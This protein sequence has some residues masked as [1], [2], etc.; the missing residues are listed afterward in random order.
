MLRRLRALLSARRLD[1]ELDAELRFH[2]EMEAEQ[3]V[4]QGLTPD[5]ARARAWRNFGPMVK[6]TEGARDQ[7]GVGAIE[8]FVQDLRYGVRIL[9]K[10]PGFAL[11]SILTLGL[12]IA[13]NT[14][15]FSVIDAAY[16]SRYPLHEPD[17]LI[18]LFNEDRERGA[19]QVITFS[20]PRYTFFRERQTSF[21]GLAAA[22]Y[23]GFTLEN[24]GDAEQIPGA[25]I[26]SDFLTTFGAS[27]LI[28]R[29]M[30]LDEEEG[31]RVVV[32]GEEMWR[33]RFG[34]SAAVLGQPLTLSGTVYTIVGVAPRLPAFW[35]ADVWLPDPFIVPGLTRELMQR[36]VTF[37]SL[38]GRLQP[39][40][41]QAEATRE[42][43]VLASR[44]GDAFP[45][46][47]DAHW[48]VTT[49]GLRDNIVGSSR[50]SL[51]TL[52]AAVGLLL[53]VAC[54]NV[55]NLLL[56]RFTGRRQEIGLRAALGASRAR[57]V[58]Q[59]L[60][61]STV[62]ATLAAA[63]GAALAYVATPALLALAQNNLAFSEDIHISLPVLGATVA[64]AL[65][66]GLVMGAYPSVQGARSDVVSALRDGG[67]TIAGAI[68]SHRARQGIVA[69]Q[70][71]V[72]L[73]LVVGAALLVTSFA[74]LRSQPTG[75]AADDA[76]VAGTNVPASRYPDPTAQNRLYRDLAAALNAAPGVI[77]AVMAQNVPLSGPSTRAP[78]ASADG[79]VPPLSERPLGLTQSV[80]PGY[81]DTLQIPLLAGRDF[82]ER[83]TADAPLVAI[84]SA[85]TARKL[86]PTDGNVLGRRIV[87]GSQGGGQV[88]EIVGVVGDVRS[89][90]LSASPDVEFYRP[91]F[92]R[93]RPFM[94]LVVRTAGDAAAFET[95]A[96]QIVRRHDPSLALTGVATLRRIVDRSLAQQ[97]LLF[98]LLSVF[99]ALAVIL[100]TV[101]I[102]GVVVFFVGQRRTEIGV[103]VALGA[104]AGE[105][106]GMV[107]RQSLPPVAAGIA[108]GTAG[109]AALARSV[110]TLLF[111]VSALDPLLLC[112]AALALAAV[113]TLACAV[114]AHRAAQIS[115]IEAIRGS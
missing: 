64:L 56:V 30:R 39:G 87:M 14:A 38:I 73:V 58:R 20:Q 50:A 32:L 26:T 13:A 74:R 96:R 103:R 12:G 86:F 41:T 36:G 10:H 68:G 8:Q 62:L 33:T 63:A 59:F 7:R 1:R 81:F 25:S 99:A 44:Y 57:I 65:V 80:T 34:A 67:R 70:V 17:R 46:N 3:Y 40:K 61:E 83:D 88:M 49:V 43:E 35:D 79:V 75:F 54:A 19:S 31:G 102:Y 27:P 53:V 104:R 98:T 18:R 51:L 97:R 91:V 22:T 92:Q 60:V 45:A 16:F 113:A 82:T 28:G 37:L 2:L 9:V 71:A 112:G 105:I 15:I 66:S 4:A 42:L 52:L 69:A 76:F 94:Q 6:H 77:K 93:P 84:V 108:L 114:P 89:Q 55:A 106:V 90:T 29:F 110:Q 111:G 47:A 78:Y 85:S 23:N 72:S 101:G 5:E 95:T 109:I 24:R 21:A 107:M 100:S 48:T 115:P 11:L